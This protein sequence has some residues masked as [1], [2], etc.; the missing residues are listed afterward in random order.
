MRYYDE[1]GRRVPDPR[2]E[3]VPLL[4]MTLMLTLG[5]VFGVLAMV[6][7]TYVWVPAQTETTAPVTFF[8]SFGT[9]GER[10]NVQIYT[11]TDPDSGR[12]YLVPVYGDVVGG[13]CP[14]EGGDI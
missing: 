9:I 4:P 5:L 8:S 2:G 14:R 12:D 10:G 3:S 11:W 1:T 13:M 7:Y 6:V